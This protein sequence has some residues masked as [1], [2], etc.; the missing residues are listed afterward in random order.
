MDV[1]N[2]VSTIA[3]VNKDKPKG[4]AYKLGDVF[5]DTGKGVAKIAAS[6][7]NALTG[8]EYDPKM[9]TGFGNALEKV[10]DFTEDV[11]TK[12]VNTATF[13]LAKKA[14]VYD[15]EVETKAGKIVGTVAGVAGLVIGGAALLGSETVAKVADKVEGVVKKGVP[16]VGDLIAAGQTLK[17]GISSDSIS[18]QKASEGNTNTGEKSNTP[19]LIG[20]VGLLIFKQKIL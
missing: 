4:F 16:L 2:L 13:G 3:T 12:A 15:G 11:Q 5:A 19:L 14:G 18:D 17:G 10:G 20:L 7:V 8:H 9:K 1:I 6:P